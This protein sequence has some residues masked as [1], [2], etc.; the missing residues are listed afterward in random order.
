[1]FIDWDI[2]SGSKTVPL[3]GGIIM[4]SKGCWQFAN[5]TYWAPHILEY[6]SNL[7]GPMTMINDENLDDVTKE[8]LKWAE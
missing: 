4:D 1:M 8:M 5:W 7:I 3:L 6:T 2:E